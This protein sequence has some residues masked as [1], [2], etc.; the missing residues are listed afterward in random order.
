MIIASHTNSGFHNESMVCRQ[1]DAHIFLS[2]NE[3]EPRGNVP[4]LTISQMTK[5]V[6]ASASEAELGV[7][8][9]TAKEMITL[10]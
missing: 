8:F 7:L 6:M 1:S 9:I 2:E 3:P 4:V 5:F 10:Q